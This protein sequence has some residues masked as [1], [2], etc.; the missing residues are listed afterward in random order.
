MSRER[1][2]GHAHGLRVRISVR[3]DEIN[4]YRSAHHG[5]LCIN[6][7]PG[8]GKSTLM[9]SAYN[10]DRTSIMFKPVAFFFNARRRGLEK[11]IESLFRSL[12]CQL[13]DEPDYHVEMGLVSGKIEIGYHKE[14][15]WSLVVLQELFREAVEC[16]TF[17]APTRRLVCY[18][19]TLD[20][21]AEDAVR[22][23]L[24][25]F[26]D[27][28]EHVAVHKTSVVLFKSAIPKYT[29]ATQSASNSFGL[30]RRA[31]TQWARPATPMLWTRLQCWPTFA[32]I[33]PSSTRKSLIGTG[34]RRPTSAIISL[35]TPG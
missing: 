27:L 12:L 16:Y 23:L 17:C 34:S 6:G 3:D 10:R 24:T 26:E 11:S 18:I 9:R 5:I 15:V 22:D 30:H 13:L 35:S 8:A 1:I 4:T 7:V 31:Y 33:V 19:D 2:Q 14:H 29:S 25:Y 28:E 32:T 20:E 21:C